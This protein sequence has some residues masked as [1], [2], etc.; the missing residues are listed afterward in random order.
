MIIYNDLIIIHS[1]LTKLH[2]IQNI[3][4]K[5]FPYIDIIY[6]YE[7]NDFQYVFLFVIERDCCL[8]S[9]TN[10]IW[11]GLFFSKSKYSDNAV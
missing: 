1:L 11:F 6:K 5:I 9:N 3:T 10:N 4:F 7:K 8:F 2:E